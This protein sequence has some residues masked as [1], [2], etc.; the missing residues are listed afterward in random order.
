MR[1]RFC[2]QRVGHACRTKSYNQQMGAHRTQYALR[3]NPQAGGGAA[4]PAFG[5]ARAREG[6]RFAGGW[7]RCQLGGASSVPSQP[8][9]GSV[10]SRAIPRGRSCK[11]CGPICTNGCG[12]HADPRVFQAARVLLPMAWM[13]RSSLAGGCARLSANVP[14]ATIAEARS[15][16]TKTPL[17]DNE[18]RICILI[19]NDSGRVLGMEN[20]AGPRICDRVA[21]EAIPSIAGRFRCGSSRSRFFSRARLRPS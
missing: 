4:G 6:K 17:A 14:V 5:P 21:L 11:I 19:D 9:E 2:C 12:L 18:F 20:D 3:W 7:P 13:L 10:A 16:A 8:Q 15:S 1:V